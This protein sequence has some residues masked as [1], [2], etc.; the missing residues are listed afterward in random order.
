MANEAT[1]IEGNPI[2]YQFTVADGTAITKG[3]LM[4]ISADP[5]TVLASSA[6]GQAFAGIITHDKVASDGATKA[7]LAQTGVWD[8]KLA[9]NSTCDFGD[10][11]IISGANLVARARDYQTQAHLYQSG[12]IVGM[13]LETGSSAEVIA[14]DIGRKG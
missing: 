11:L 9:T 7:S 5:R 4:Y 12:M 14:V 13:A 2:E 1:I 10:L 6:T 8:I 3:T